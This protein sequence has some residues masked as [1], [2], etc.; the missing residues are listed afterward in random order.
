MILQ[1]EGLFW[2]Q[3]NGYYLEIVLQTQYHRSLLLSH[4]ADF[5]HTKHIAKL[6]VSS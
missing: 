2:I 3:K 4:V 6:C 5:L 1:F